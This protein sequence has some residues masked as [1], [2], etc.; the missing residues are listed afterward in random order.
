[1]IAIGL[2][3][4][5]CDRQDEAA[6]QARQL[7]APL[8]EAVQPGAGAPH[9]PAYAISRARAGQPID[10][11]FTRRDDGTGGDMPMRL[12]ELRGTPLIVNLWATWCVPCRKELPTLD[13]LAGRAGDRF[14]VLAI[15]QDRE[16]AT[17]VDPY[18]AEAGFA[19]LEPYLD[20]EGRVYD[21]AGASAIPLT[22][23]I[24]ADGREV[25]RVIGV[26]D[27]AGPDGAR[28]IEEMMAAQPRGR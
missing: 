28:L 6:E 10:A 9:Q 15:A 17:L 26:L 27:W 13:R 4:G 11:A 23:L 3:L 20:P 24:D 21:A 16:G 8:R 18:F 2:L 5:A 14:A 22:I 19:H 12:A 7:N 25:L 1:M